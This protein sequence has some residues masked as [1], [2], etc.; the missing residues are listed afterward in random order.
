MSFLRARG[1]EVSTLT[2]VF[3][4]FSSP[5]SVLSLDLEATTTTKMRT[6]R[7]K[8]FEGTLEG[9]SH[10]LFHRELSADTLLL[11]LVSPTVNASENPTLLRNQ[12]I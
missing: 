5:L 2:F 3:R 11:S 4:S 10:F 12:P 9:E 1:F 6:T 8:E 7:W